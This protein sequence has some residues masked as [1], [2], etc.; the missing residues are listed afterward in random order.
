MGILEHRRIRGCFSEPR[1]WP[2]SHQVVQ[3]RQR[4]IDTMQGQVNSRRSTFLNHFQEVDPAKGVAS[5][6]PAIAAE[7]AGAGG[8]FAGERGDKRSGS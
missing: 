6:D 4:Y 3:T 2:K 5:N 8:R 1:F 7:G